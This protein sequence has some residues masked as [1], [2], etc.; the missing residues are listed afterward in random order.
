MFVIL[1][2]FFLLN[3]RELEI[4]VFRVGSHSISLANW[5]VTY[6]PFCHLHSVTSCNFIFSLVICDYYCIFCLTKLFYLFLGSHKNF[7]HRGTVHNIIKYE[8][9]Q[10]ASEGKSSKRCVAVHGAHEVCYNV[11]Y[12]SYC[13]LFLFLKQLLWL[14]YAETSMGAEIVCWYLVCDW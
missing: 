3:S 1:D 11:S 5:S 6:D 7:G 2:S 8:I 4:G 10:N 13:I 9:P 12:S 14:I